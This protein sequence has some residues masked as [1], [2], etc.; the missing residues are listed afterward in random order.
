MSKGTISNN[1]A[2]ENG[3]GVW[4]DTAGWSGT[5]ANAQIT[6][7]T[8]GGVGVDEY[9]EKIGGNTAK[10]GGGIYVNNSKLISVWGGTISNNT[11]IENGGG[12]YSAYD[13]Q[14][15][16]SHESIS[17]APTISSNEAE[18]NGAGISMNSAKILYIWNETK[19][20]DNTLL[21]DTGVGEG[22]YIYDGTSN[23]YIIKTASYN[24]VKR[25]TIIS[26]KNAVYIKRTSTPRHQISFENVNISSEQKAIIAEN[27][28]IE[29]IGITCIKGSG[30][31]FINSFFDNP[32]VSYNKTTQSWIGNYDVLGW[33]EQQ[34]NNGQN[35][36]YV[37]NRSSM[38]KVGMYVSGGCKIQNPHMLYRNGMIFRMQFYGTN[39]ATLQYHGESMACASA[40]NFF[41]GANY[42]HDNWGQQGH[43][44]QD[45][46]FICI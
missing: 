43:Y 24:T 7:G 31:E 2:S 16:L 35:P 42:S 27:V 28:E 3:G 30:I 20:I 33:R 22:L 15:F 21:S 37:P 17:Y 9:G 29:L 25:P 44:D 13:S 10:N 5:A 46:Y 26:K 8:I 14:L 12:I 41:P 23:E 40:V 39:N 19:I 32:Q 18:S 1:T 34:N 38:T 4:C 11:A 45:V 6:G 36:S